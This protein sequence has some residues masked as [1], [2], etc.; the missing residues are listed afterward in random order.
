[1][2]ALKYTAGAVLG[3]ISFLMLAAGLGTNRIGEVIGAL[4]VLAAGG[5]LFAWAHG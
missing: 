4:V 2:K 3:G 1:M 5:A